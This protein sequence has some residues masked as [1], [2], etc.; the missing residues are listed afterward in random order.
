[1]CKVGKQSISSAPLHRDD[2][3]L[4]LQRTVSNSFRRIPQTEKKERRCKIKQELMSSIVSCRYL[5]K[6][7]CC[8]EVV[9][10]R[11]VRLTWVLQTFVVKS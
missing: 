10:E 2:T 4:S 1:M 8:L 7:C 6:L 9:D 5:F 3:K 11:Y